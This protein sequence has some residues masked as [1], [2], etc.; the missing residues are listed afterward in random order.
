PRAKGA[1][2]AVP[3]TLTPKLVNSCK[4]RLRRYLEEEG[5]KGLERDDGEPTPGVVV[6]TTY[7]WSRSCCHSDTCLAPVEY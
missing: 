3:A 5:M 7:L 1:I 6:A 4:V 2:P